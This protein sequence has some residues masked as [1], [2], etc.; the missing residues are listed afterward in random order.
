M[1]DE[2]FRDAVLFMQHARHQRLFDPGKR[3]VCHGGSR[4]YTQR[5]TCKAPLAEE[6]TGGGGGGGGG[7]GLFRCNREPHFA[8][9]EV[10]H[11]IRRL[12]L[13]EDV[14][15]RA[16]FCNR[17]ADRDASEEGFPIDRLV[18]LTRHDG[19]RQLAEGQA[20]ASKPPG[21]AHGAGQLEMQPGKAATQIPARLSLGWE[22]G[23]SPPEHALRLS[24]SAQTLRITQQHTTSA[25][26]CQ[27]RSRC[28][29]QL[30]FAHYLLGILYL[31][32]GNAA[33]AVP[34]LEIARRAFSKEPKVYFALGNAYARTGCKEEAARARAEFDR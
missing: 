32:S 16:V 21:L 33:G 24:C 15:V 30:P 4:G 13:P 26:W 3:T 31:D 19:L 5:L 28:S 8:P 10:E 6:F 25:A 23:T 20:V 18:F 1:R 9:L 12:S 22:V 11:G 2:Q 7:G 29:M 34:E 17:L 14:A 27:F